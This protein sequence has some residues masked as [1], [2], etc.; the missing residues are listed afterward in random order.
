MS[1]TNHTNDD[2]FDGLLD[3][4]PVADD[5]PAA[6][7][8]DADEKP[9][10]EYIEKAKTRA[11]AAGKRIGAGIAVAFVWLAVALLTIPKAVVGGVLTR[12][13][14]GVAVGQALHKASINIIRKKGD[15]QFV[16][17]TIYG[18]GAVIPR[19]AGIDADTQWAETDNG[20]EW[21]AENGVDLCRVG[22]APVAFGV[23]D[24]HEM[25]SPIRARLAEKID[26]G[27]EHW[28]CIREFDS[29]HVEDVSYGRMP[30]T[31]TGGAARAD[32]GV[33]QNGHPAGGVPGDGINSEMHTPKFDDI[34]VDLSNWV[35]D[36]DG[37]IVSMKKA[38]ETTHQKGSTEALE[39]AETRGRIAERFN[40]SDTK[41]AIY[42]ILTALGFL[43]L[44]LFGPSL[45]GQLGGGG[46]GGGGGLGGVSPL[47]VESVAAMWG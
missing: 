45:A 44:G 35:D 21:V 36:A 15:A 25:V 6:D 22:D 38:Y 11:T 42:L 13:P 4:E 43:C 30:A 5:E 7:E 17:Y 19:P 3:D 33:A 40:D 2:D 24:D 26:S 10:R 16:T 46:G 8:D 18:D 32:G 37:M 31:Q 39:T 28:R 34:W 23:A 9:R 12:M 27:D 20:E 47:L 1:D 14:K 41:W 29:G